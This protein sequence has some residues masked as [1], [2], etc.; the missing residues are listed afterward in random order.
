[1]VDL[2]ERAAVGMAGLEVEG[3]HLA[4]PAVHPQQD[5]RAAAFGVRRGGARQACQPARQGHAGEAQGGQPQPVAAAWGRMHGWSDE[6][7]RVTTNHTNH[8]KQDRKEGKERRESRK[9]ASPS[10]SLL[11][12]ILS[13]FCLVSCDSCGSW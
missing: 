12:L 6:G 10:S 8:T 3:V 9:P 4:R 5:A 13:P 2:L 7:K 11:T 1:G